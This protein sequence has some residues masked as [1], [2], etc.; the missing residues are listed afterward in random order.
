MASFDIRFPPFLAIKNVCHFYGRKPALRNISLNA[1]KSEVLALLGPSGSGKSTLLASIAGM[2]TPSEGE[3]LLGGRNILASPPEKRGLGMVF[4]DFALWPH[5]TVAQNVAFP[6]RVRRLGSAEV[7]ARTEKALARVGLAEFAARRPHELSGGQQQRVALARAVVAETEL[8]LLD[9]PLSALDPA[10]R[11]H[12][13]SELADILRQLDLTTIIVTHDRE[14]AFELADRVA[15]LIDGRI[16]QHSTPKEIYERPANLAVARFMGTN[17]LSVRTRPD[18]SAEVNGTD[19]AR[20]AIFRL[21]R[22]GAAHAA[23]VPERIGLTDDARAKNVLRGHLERCQYRGGEY[24]LRVIIGDDKAGQTIE[25]RS[26]YAP[27][28]STLYVQ[29]PPE[30]LHIIEETLRPEESAVVGALSADV[31][32]TQ[33]QEKTA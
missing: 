16:Q 8:L 25:V 20:L 19:G 23:I 24:R 33:L 21:A 3:I 22:E 29:L 10:T 11:S 13:R 28:E 32:L 5:M 2:I 27:Q 6:L 12:V 18:G 31:E 9:E 30:S 26:K 17:V 14:E 15:V 4:Q 7:A 1:S